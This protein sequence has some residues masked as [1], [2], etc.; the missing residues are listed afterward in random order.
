MEVEDIPD[1][2]QADSLEDSH[3]TADKTEWKGS[4]EERTETRKV[5]RGEEMR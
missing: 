3:Y 1:C 2:M 4:R 5:Q